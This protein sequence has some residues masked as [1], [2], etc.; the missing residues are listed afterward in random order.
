MKF[1]GDAVLHAPVDRVWS[2]ILDPT[3]LVRT[4]PGCERLEATGENAYAMTV[5]AGVAAI[6]GTYS[7]S[8][9]LSDLDEHSSLMMK[10]QGAGAPGTIGADVV[11][12]FVDGGDGTTT[13]TYDADA[14][15]GG[16]VGGVGQ[17]M[18]S[19]VSRRMAGEFFANLDAVLTGI[20]ATVAAPGVVAVGAPVT[21]SETPSGAAV[22]TA[23]ARKSGVSS[24]EDLLKGIAVGAGLVLLGVL[25]GS[26]LGRRR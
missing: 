10:L 2:A 8:C 9:A 12:G 21:L 14:V 18:L 16:M 19:S 20:A 5:T 13:I 24:Q 6:K 22:F 11:V 23:P 17:R 4:I 26:L 3:V 1:T 7:G 25:A 15:V